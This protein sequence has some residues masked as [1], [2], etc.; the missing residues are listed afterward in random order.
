MIRNRVNGYPGRIE[1]NSENVA[2]GKP[3]DY[4][5]IVIELVGEDLERGYDVASNIIAAASKVDGVRNVLVKEDDSNHELI[6]DINRDLVSKMGIN[7]NTI[8]NIIRTSFSGTTAS[9]MTLNNSIYVD[10]DIIVRLEDT[11]RDTISTIQKMMIPTSNGIIPISSVVDIHKATGPT[12]INRKNDKRII[13]ISASSFGRP[14]N[15]IINDIR[16][17]INNIYT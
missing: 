12:E 11:N 13:E 16:K 8:A 4:S 2:L 7:I 6:F 5:A 17:E 14:I 10:T 15:E 9:K 1:L 3:K